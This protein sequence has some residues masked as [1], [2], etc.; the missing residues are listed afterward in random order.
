MAALAAMLCLWLLGAAES[1]DTWNQAVEMFRVRRADGQIEFVDHEDFYNGPSAAKP[2]HVVAVF[3]TTSGGKSTACR[4]LSCSMQMPTQFPS[5]TIG[6]DHEPTRGLWGSRMVDMDGAEVVVLDIEG[7][8][9]SEQDQKVSEAVLK[10]L[11]LLSEV[12]SVF[13]QVRR[14][15]TIQASDLEYIATFVSQVRTT[16]LKRSFTANGEAGPTDNFPALLIAHVL[17]LR[18]EASV[19]AEKSFEMTKQALTAQPAVIKTINENYVELFRREDVGV[20]FDYLPLYQLPMY[21]KLQ[22]MIDTSTTPGELRRNVQGLIDMNEDEA[23]PLHKAGQVYLDDIDALR[24]KILAMS[25]VRTDG[26]DRTVTPKTFRQLLKWGVHEMNKVGPLSNVHLW[27]KIAIDACTKQLQETITKL[28]LSLKHEADEGDDLFA[29]LDAAER[30][31]ESFFQS[32]N[33]KKDGEV[34]AACSKVRASTWALASGPYTK[35]AMLKE[36][37]QLRRE[38]QEREKK[39]QEVEAAR[40]KTLEEKHERWKDYLQQNF[41]WVALMF[42]SAAVIVHKFSTALASCFDCFRRDPSRGQDVELARMRRLELE[43]METRAQMGPWPGQ[44]AARR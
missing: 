16:L 11:A 38:A 28:E 15:P 13:V 31:L 32:L 5:S 34:Y 44:E 26:Q 37:E 3:G 17:P 42:A 18:M 7:F 22:N 6:P 36:R 40:Q 39:L 33:L 20:H 25:R 23:S 41:P 35:K 43:L 30:N 1:T 9:N 21:R 8:D 12:T 19:V 29:A 27:E 2:L 24:D 14:T 10:L 4:F